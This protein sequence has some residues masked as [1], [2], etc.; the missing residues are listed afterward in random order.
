M[1]TSPFS[2]LL[3][4]AALFALVVVPALAVAPAPTE[5]DTNPCP[6]SACRYTWNPV[7]NCCEPDPRFD[8]VVICY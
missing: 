8:C 5:A 2:K 6:T 4:L 3:K 7:E 1:K